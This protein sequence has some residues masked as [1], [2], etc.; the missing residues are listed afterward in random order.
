M[1]GEYLGAIHEAGIGEYIEI[2][3]ADKALG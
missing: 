2:D 3:V 1:R